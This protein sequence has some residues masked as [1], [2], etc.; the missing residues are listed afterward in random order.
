MR[1]RLSALS[2]KRNIHSTRRRPRN[3]VCRIPAT[4]LIQPNT[5]ST[6]L[7]FFW[8]C[9][10]PGSFL[11]SA[12]NPPSQGR[13]FPPYSATCGTTRQLRKRSRNARS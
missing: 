3:L 9:S 2:A 7:R 1:S 12:C 8:L 11:S 13:G 6:R 4:S 10:N 5:C